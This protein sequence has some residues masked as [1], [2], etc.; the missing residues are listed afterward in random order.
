[1]W[2]G[3]DRVRSSYMPLFPGYL[4]VWADH[5]SRQQAL[6]TN[7]VANCLHVG[8]ETQ[9]RS[10]LMRMYGLIR[11]DSLLSPED[12]LQP[13]T[14]VEIVKGALQGLEGTVVR[15]GSQL[16]FVVAVDFMQRGASVEIESWMFRPL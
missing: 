1:Q 13:G 16:R 15:R 8:D 14:R 11:S 4:F 10:D 12:R 2:R 3:R 5:S 7:L 6:Q 9:L